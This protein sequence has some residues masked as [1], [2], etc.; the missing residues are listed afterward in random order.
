MNIR[1]GGV[2]EHFNLPWELA[3]ERDLFSQAGVDLDWTFYAGGTGAMTKALARGDLDMA[4]LLTEG[5]ISAVHNGL[6]ASIVKVYIDSPMRWGIHTG[7][8]NALQEVSNTDPARIAI[9]RFGSGSHLMALIHAE[10]RKVE[11]NENHFVVVNSLHG[12]I[13]SLVKNE[14]DLFYW[15]PFMTK[16]FVTAGQVRRIGTFSAPWS[17]FLVVAS[18][19]ALRLKAGAI[20]R[21]LDLM[22][23][24]CVRFKKMTESIHQLTQRFQMNAEEARQWLEDTQWNQNY[25]AELELLVN[26]RNALTRVNACSK[27][28]RVEHLCHDWITLI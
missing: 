21:T 15:E 12:A 1:I 23:A 9:S 5:F 3:M 11:L 7:H 6:E 14:T 20:K 18:K 19:Q 13:D 8:H 25:Y 22:N 28:L 16:P 2:P 4:I 17:S 27:S 24:E 26:S 10:Q